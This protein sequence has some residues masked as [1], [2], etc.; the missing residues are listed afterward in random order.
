M[1]IDRFIQILE[2]LDEASIAAAAAELE[3]ST[4]SA[5]G[6]VSWWRATVAIDR[7]L[8]ARRVGRQAAQAAHRAS[9]AVLR[10]AARNGNSLPDDL[11]TSVARAAADVARGIAA[12]SAATDDLLAGCRH[13]ATGRHLVAA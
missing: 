5:A 4:A 10:A 8:R 13:L 9:T 7:E 3:E 12:G 6:E 11:V 1:D 2:E